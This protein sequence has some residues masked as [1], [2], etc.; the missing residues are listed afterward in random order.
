MSIVEHSAEWRTIANRD[1]RPSD[2]VV[3]AFPQLQALLVNRAISHAFETHERSALRWKWRYTILGRT[4]LICI[5]VVMVFFDYEFVLVRP[6]GVSEISQMLATALAGVG[7]ASQLAIILGRVKERWL[8]ERFAAE[9][10]RCLKFQAFAVAAC[11]KDAEQLASHVLAF[12]TQGIAHLDQELMGGR[13]ALEQFSPSE[14]SVIPHLSD[15]C[16]NSELIRDAFRVYDSTRLE[17]Q[18]Q[19]FEHCSHVSDRRAR[20]P[21]LL[22]EITF[23]MGG[24]LAFGQI[25]ASAWQGLEGKEPILLERWASFLTLLFFVLSAILAVYQRGAADAPDAERYRHYARELRR[26][27]TRGEPRNPEEFLQI[28]EQ[29]EQVELR[30]LFDFCRDA[31]HSSYIS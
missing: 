19:H 23:V 31:M 10:L 8:V 17:V 27:R 25:C 21:T 12:T 11:S 30:E 15:T 26:I 29:T 18:A 24:M 22:S 2:Q 6:Q 7:V 16:T 4:A 13:A 3:N 1:I 28:V 9:R 5:F 20:M 14:L